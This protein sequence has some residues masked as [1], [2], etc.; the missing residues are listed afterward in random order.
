MLISPLSRLRSAQGSPFTWGALFGSLTRRLYR[1]TQAFLNRD[2]QYFGYVLDYLRNGGSLPANLPLE[3]AELARVREEF[4]FFC[5]GDLFGK[6]SLVE[7]MAAK[8]YTSRSLRPSKT[9]S[10][11]TVQL[12]F[13]SVDGAYA[14]ILYQGVKAEGRSRWLEA[15]ELDSDRPGY[16]LH[17]P[18]AEPSL[19]SFICGFRHEVAFVSGTDIVVVD[20]RKSH[21]EGNIAQTIHGNWE[22]GDAQ[23]TLCV[24]LTDKYVVTADAAL[25]HTTVWDRQSGQLA[26][27]VEVRGTC[28]GARD[29]R[30]FFHNDVVHECQ[31]I[32]LSLPTDSPPITQFADFALGTMTWYFEGTGQLWTLD[33]VEGAEPQAKLRV[34]D[35]D[36][37][38]LVS[39]RT[40]SCAIPNTGIKMQVIARDDAIVWG[41][42]D[43]STETMNCIDVR[44][45][46]HRV[47]RTGLCESFDGTVCSR[48]ENRWLFSGTLAW[49]PSTRPSCTL[50]PWMT[51]V[52]VLC[53]V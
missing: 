50:S 42:S 3:E 2:P 27:T 24:S 35:C 44:S 25:G 45:G 1:A 12:G 47:V 4:D 20:M 19:G 37:M 17:A 51:R 43:G 36:S 48:A 39:Q 31:V 16:F 22:V 7:L 11:P 9:V 15:C 26:R 14:A 40:F 49:A 33:A 8:D 21:A 10:V 32:E 18:G 29:T 41:N 53:T 6:K 46:E 38:A 52:D 5:M 34:Y 23:D 13:L 30:L 28:V